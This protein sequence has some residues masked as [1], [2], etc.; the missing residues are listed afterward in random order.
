[1]IAALACQLLLLA[2]HQATTFFDLHPFN[3]ARNYARRERLAEMGAN[4]VLMSLAPIGF[5]LGIHGLQVYGVVYY[6]VLFAIELVIWWVPYFFDPRG[7]SRAVYN[8]ILAAATSNFGSDDALAHWK[9]THERLHV[10]TITIVPR[11]AGRIV[12][13]LE[14]TLLH[15]WTLVTAIVTY[16][17][18]HGLVG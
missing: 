15:V 13:N 7:V 5:A 18:V 6:F 12:P 8:V 3:G 2:Y 1:M 9:R 16:R 4:A 11:R 14:H 17:A 10:G